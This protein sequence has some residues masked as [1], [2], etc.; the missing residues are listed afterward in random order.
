MRL[1]LDEQHSPEVAHQLRARGHDVDAVA[2]RPEL[3]TL[4]DDVLLDVAA[5]D[6]RALMTEDV[7]DFM[8]EHRRRIAEGRTHYGIVFT[9][10]FSRRKERIGGLIAAIAAFLD[11]RPEDDALR[12]EVAWL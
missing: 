4:E 8:Y 2:A 1:L 3:V 11:A 6:R 10:R 9:S 12:N 7:R 5:A